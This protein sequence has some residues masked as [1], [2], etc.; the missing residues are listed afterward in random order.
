MNTDNE[1]ILDNYFKN[2]NLSEELKKFYQIINEEEKENY[3][4]EEIKLMDIRNENYIKY[5]KIDLSKLNILPHDFDGL[6]KKIKDTY[7]SIEM[8]DLLKNDFELA[9]QNKKIIDNIY[10]QLAE[11]DITIERELF[12]LECENNRRQTLLKHQTFDNFNNKTLEQ[13]LNK[14][15]NIVLYNITT[16]HDI[17]E[18][19]KRQWHRKKYINDL[20]RFINIEMEDSDYDDN[21]IY[22]L[23]DINSK[24]EE[25]IKKMSDKIIYLEDLI[26]EGSTNLE[27][28][29]E[30]KNDFEKLIAYDDTNYISASKVYNLLCKDSKYQLLINY[31]E[32]MFL[33]ERHNKESEEKFIYEKYGIKN[34]KISLDYIVAN[35]MNY[36]NEEDK[37]LINNLYEEINTTDY[38]I[39]DVYNSLKKIVNNIWKNAITDV[40]SYEEGND[41]CFICAN[42]QFIDEK[43]Q[44]ILITKKMLEKVGD[45]SDYQIG[46]VCGYNDNILYVTENEDIMSVQYNDMSNL[47]TPKQIEQ[48]FLNFKVC[49]RIAL[50]GYITK[51]S[52]VYFIN[53]GDFI[54]YK[55]AVELANQ[56][57]LPLIILKKDKS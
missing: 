34:I 13:I 57:N 38:N 25:E 29:L 48:E 41:F 18:N 33:N 37:K 22:L 44:S 55:K 1:Y 30:F 32:E 28:F 4:G 23:S 10:V 45:Y 53:D 11:L 6:V 43:Y 35:Y 14:Y 51:I 47:K 56:Y 39:D 19:Y 26:V 3:I 50:D 17:Y 46:F 36:I 2:V 54:K 52:A 40:Y 31:F 49:N 27:Q 5:C 9:T 8:E 12:L 7:K 16:K 24:I 15:N 20:Y 42:N 21:Y